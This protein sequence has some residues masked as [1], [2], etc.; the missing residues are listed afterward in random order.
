MTYGRYVKCGVLQVKSKRIKYAKKT[1]AAQLVIQAGALTEGGEIFILDM[2]K[3]LK[4]KDLAYDL[5][6]MS[7]LQ[8]E[9]D[10]P[11]VYSGIRPGEKL[12]EELLTTE[13]G[14]KQTKH[15]RIFAVKPSAYPWDYLLQKL[16]ELERLVVEPHH[17]GREQKLIQ[18]LYSILPNYI[19]PTERTESPVPILETHPGLVMSL[20]V[21]QE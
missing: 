21:G 4:V 2:G 19:P 8:P 15:E 10:I 11:I 20:S 9:R 13:E 17:Q 7:G 6:R 18:M 12:Y 3:P 1:V 5:I 16:A 14:V